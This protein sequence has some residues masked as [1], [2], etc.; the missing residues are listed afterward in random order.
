MNSTNSI[1]DDDNTNL[2]L[3]ILEPLSVIIKLAI[4]TTKKS[5]SNIE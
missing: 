5:R 1:P 4:I 2:H 3:S